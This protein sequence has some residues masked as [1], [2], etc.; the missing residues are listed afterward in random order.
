M[1]RRIDRKNLSADDLLN[2]DYGPDLGRFFFAAP[3]FEYKPTISCLKKIDQLNIQSHSIDAPEGLSSIWQVR[4]EFQ[5]FDFYVDTNHHGTTS[6]FFV[7][8]T[9]CPDKVLLDLLQIF[10]QFGPL[11]WEQPE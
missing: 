11:D 1:N 7:S 3:D 8:D 6:M 5:G 10:G 2:E 4:F 9:N